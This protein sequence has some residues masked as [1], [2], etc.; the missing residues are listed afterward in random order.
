MQGSLSIFAQTFAH[1]FAQV[2]TQ[3]LLCP[4]SFVSTDDQLSVMAI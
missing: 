4:V 1:A 3:I 2:S